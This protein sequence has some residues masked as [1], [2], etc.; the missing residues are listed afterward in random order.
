[1]VEQYRTFVDGV[2]RRAGLAESEEAGRAAVAVIEAV[3][4]HL[5]GVD[6]AQLATAL[7]AAVRESV[8]WDVP[9]QRTGQQADLVAE[10]ARTADVAPE[11]AR[12]LV[13]AVLS[14]ISAE[15]RAVAD[16]LRHRLPDEFAE[17]FTAPGGGPPPDRSSAATHPRPFDDDE[18]RRALAELDGWSGT[19]E[20]IS[21]EVFLPRD[22]WRPLL[23]QVERAQAELSHHASVEERPESLVFSLRTRSVDSVTEL[24]LALARQV[25]DAVGSVGSGG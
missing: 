7:P 10:T 24:D 23:N 19:R 3:A 15:D 5:D 25:D 16:T 20:R 14:E 12:Y 4:G 1:M 18:L 8:H 11:N 22:R 2:R 21:R 17:M 13:Q 9:E 6:R